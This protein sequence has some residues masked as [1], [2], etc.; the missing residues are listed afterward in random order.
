MRRGSEVSD[1]CRILQSY[2]DAGLFA[3]F[4][5]TQSTGTIG[6][7]ALAW[8][9]LPCA[10]LTVDVEATEL[11]LLHVLPRVSSGSPMGRAY[12]QFL[13]NL[14][15][16]DRPAHR[17][18][19]SGKV[20]VASKATRRG[21]A[22]RLRV[23]DRDYDYATRALVRVVQESIYEFIFDGPYYDYRVQKLGVDPDRA[24]IL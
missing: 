19:D 3:S 6:T 14:S 12:R 23:I 17:R 15:A 13:C 4:A 22:L 20:K 16:A 5:V 1:V 18:I 11:T 10:T 7:F 2:A 21:L 8:R 9:Y 24:A